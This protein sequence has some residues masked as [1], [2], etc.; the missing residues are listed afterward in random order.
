VPPDLPA[1]LNQNPRII[2]AFGVLFLIYYGLKVAAQAS[3]TFASML[4]GLGRRWMS[5][6]Q[7]A[8]AAA[9]A[10]RTATNLVV[11][12]MRGELKHFVGRVE[13]LSGQVQTL[14]ENADLRDDY[15]AYDTE[16]HAEIDRHAAAVGWE[17]PPPRH[18]SFTEFARARQSGAT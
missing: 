5:Q 8:Q 16:W 7:R 9:E 6:K 13:R 2:T 11:E 3:D 1:V 4:G 14:Q 17:F 12:D 10:G 15:L 18:L